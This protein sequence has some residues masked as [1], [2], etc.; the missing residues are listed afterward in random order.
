MTQ[1]RTAWRRSYWSLFT[2]WR[3]CIARIMP[4]QDV[5]LSVRS[6]VY[7]SVCLSH[8]GIMWKWLHISSKFFSPS[9]SPA[10][11][12][13]PYETGWQYSDGDSPNGVV[14][15]KGVWKN[16]DFRPISH[17]ISQMMQYRAIVYYGSRIGNRT[18]AFEW[19]RFEWPWVTS[20][21][22]FK[23]MILFNVK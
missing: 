2:A 19:Y 1:I 8:C 7:L 22:D 5:C 6:S 10:N 16:Y 23:V 17:F 18:Q 21:P 20:N 4:W 14:E 13:F 12:V 3:V 9:C 11:L 15:C